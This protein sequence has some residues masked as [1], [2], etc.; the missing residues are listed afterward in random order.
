MAEALRLPKDSMT[1]LSPQQQARMLE[2][3]KTLAADVLTDGEHHFI[4][5]GGFAFR[6]S[7]TH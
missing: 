1:E 4:L 6:L 7:V 2:L 5:M 3:S